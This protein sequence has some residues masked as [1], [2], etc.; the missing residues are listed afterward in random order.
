[1]KIRIA[2]ITTSRSDYGPAY[3][4]IHDLFADSRFDFKL[5]AGGSHLSVQHGATI[6]EIEQDGWPVEARVPFLEE[7]DDDI[8]YGRAFGKALTLYS[9]LFCKLRPDI[10][11][12]CGDRIELLPIVSSAVLSRIPIAHL[13]GGDITGGAIDDQVRHAVTKMSHIHFPSTP[14]S[15]ERILQMGEEPWRVHAV[16]DPALDHFV[17]G[18]HASPVELAAVLGFLPDRHTLL[19]TFHPATLEIEDMPRQTAELAAAICRYDGP[20]VITAPAPDPG[21]ACIRAEWERLLRS[22]PRTYLLASMGGY[23]Y[24]GLMR[25]VGAM[26]GNSSSG[27]IEAASIPLPVVNVGSRQSGREHSSNVL[28]VSAERGL[29]E[30]GILTALSDSFRKSLDKVVSVYG[31][32]HAAVRIVEIL[33]KSPSRNQLLQKKFS[34]FD[35]FPNKAS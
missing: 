9:E 33:A 15:A 10:L 30:R 25:L 3:W 34:R 31:D 24:R 18:N 6:T 23:R 5:L 22:R 16:G 4:L 35:G 17:R 28:D 7:G 20:V 19:V 12:V 21:S 32:G 2:Y 1:M 11:M 26:V 8:S 13:C 29:I 14:R 27:L